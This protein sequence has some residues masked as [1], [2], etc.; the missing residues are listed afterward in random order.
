MP[1]EIKKHHLV[2]GT[3]FTVEQLSGGGRVAAKKHPREGEL[4]ERFPVAHEAGAYVARLI[5]KRL[6]RKVLCGKAYVEGLSMESPS[7]QA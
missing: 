6:M 1:S 3:S 2:P 4:L 7:G 5:R